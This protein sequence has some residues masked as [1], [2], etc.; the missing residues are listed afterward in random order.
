MLSM[1]KAHA[2]HAVEPEPAILGVI[3]TEEVGSTTEKHAA[4]GRKY[5]V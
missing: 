2:A 5:P 1:G 3:R 4:T